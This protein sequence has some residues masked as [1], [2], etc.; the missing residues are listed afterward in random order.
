MEC[1]GPLNAAGACE[2]CEDG[3][4]IPPRDP[5][6]PLDGG[7]DEDCAGC[8]ELGEVQ[9]PRHGECVVENMRLLDQEAA[10]VEALRVVASAPPELLGAEAFAPDARAAEVALRRRA[11]RGAR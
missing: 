6:E 10:V 3:S 5:D 7:G 11:G 4:F 2:G 9:C 8:S 1:S